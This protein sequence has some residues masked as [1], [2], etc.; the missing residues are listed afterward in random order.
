MVISS[1]SASYFQNFFD[2]FN[3]L[4]FLSFSLL[5]FLFMWLLYFE[6]Y[7]SRNLERKINTFDS[8]HL[9][10]NLML[11]TTH[12]FNYHHAVFLSCVIYI[13]SWSCLLFC[14]LL[15]FF[16]YLCKIL[17]RH[18]STRLLNVLLFFTHSLQFSLTSLLTSLEYSPL[19]WIPTILS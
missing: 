15:L 14:L 4:S 8:S 18:W 1:Y 16:I 9:I 13:Y 11:I 12:L 10:E 17:R 7:F 2:I 19:Y 6:Y 3:L 5:L